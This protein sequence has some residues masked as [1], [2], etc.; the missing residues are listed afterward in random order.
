MDT[1]NVST[2]CICESDQWEYYCRLYF[3]VDTRDIA[4]TYLN[5][6]LAIKQFISLPT[7]LEFLHT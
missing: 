6:E 5:I 2:L 1:I 3:F 7:N 4:V